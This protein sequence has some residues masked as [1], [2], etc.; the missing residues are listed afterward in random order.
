VAPAEI[1]PA[2]KGEK[3]MDDVA[4]ANPSMLVTTKSVQKYIEELPV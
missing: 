2:G 3:A 4:E 1:V